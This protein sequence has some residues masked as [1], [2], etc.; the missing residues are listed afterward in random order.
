MRKGWFSQL[1]GNG[2]GDCIALNGNLRALEWIDCS[3]S[4]MSF[5]CE[6]IENEKDVVKVYGTTNGF[7]L[8]ASFKSNATDKKFHISQLFADAVWR[9]ISNFIRTNLK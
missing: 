9:S 7:A 6:S 1:I 4:F 8:L 5:V 3:E 2:T